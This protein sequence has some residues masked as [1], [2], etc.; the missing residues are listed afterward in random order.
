MTADRDHRG[1][2]DTGLLHQYEGRIAKTHANVAVQGRDVVECTITRIM[3]GYRERLTQFGRVCVR[4][5]CQYVGRGTSQ[6]NECGVDAIH[7]RA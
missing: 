2:I 7:T 1:C 5:G 3:Y 6:V 4:V